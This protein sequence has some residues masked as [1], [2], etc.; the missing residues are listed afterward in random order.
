MLKGCYK[1]WFRIPCYRASLVTQMVKNRPAVPETWVRSLGQED[2]LE[3]GIATHSSILAW[4]IPCTEEAGRLQSMESQRVGYNWS[5]NTYTPWYHLQVESKV[6]VLSCSDVSDSLW[7]HGLY[8]P[9]SSVHGVFPARILEWI[10]M[11]SSRGSSQRRDWT[12]V[13]HTTGRFFTVWA[14]REAQNLKY[15]TDKLIYRTETE[16][17]HRKPTLWLLLYIK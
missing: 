5:T 9:G 8:Q 14:T 16:S 7:S 13:S 17:R 10:A 1:K 15:N 2:L 4:K 11:H 12:Q 3:K 6:C